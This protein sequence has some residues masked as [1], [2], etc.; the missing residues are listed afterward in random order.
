L[1]AIIALFA[2]LPTL[3]Q[4]QVLVEPG[5]VT[6]YITNATDPG[7]G[8]TWIQPAF[9]D[10]TWDSDP[11]GLGYETGSGA[12]NLYQTMTPVDAISIYTRTDF[13]VTDPAQVFNV[14]LGFDYDDGYVAW[15]NGVE[16]ARSASMPA[17]APNWDTLC[18]NH[19][20]SNAMFPVYEFTD[21]SAQAIP[22]LNVGINTFAVGA[23]N[24]TVF[25]CDLVIVPRLSIN[26]PAQVTRGP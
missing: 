5:T 19:E 10:S 26:V 3:A 2:W 16:V 6:R 11:F 9:D 1:L 15:I 25:S 22:L 17:G 21:I 20:S 7:V 14:L 4:E 23:W 12:E 24:S 13:T 18:A 8:S